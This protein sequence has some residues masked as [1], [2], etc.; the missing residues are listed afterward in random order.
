VILTDDQT[1]DGEA[2]YQVQAALDEANAVLSFLRAPYDMG[3]MRGGGVGGGGPIGGGGPWGGGGQGPWGTGGGPWGGGGTT[4]PGGRRGPMGS[5]RYPG[6]TTIGMD[7]S[8]SAGTAE[9]AKS[10]GG[11]VMSISDAS[12]FQDTLERLRQRYAL[13]FYWPEGSTDPERRTVVVSLA[14]STGARYARSEVRYRRAY[15]ATG[16]GRRTG[17]LIE[18]SREADPTDPPGVAPGRGTLSAGQSSER[19]SGNDAVPSQARAKR[20]VAVNESSG[21]LVNAVGVEPDDQSGRTSAT[22]NSKAAE[23]TQPNPA[24]EKRGGWPRVDEAKT[25]PNEGGPIGR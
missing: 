10:T 15:L 9:I 1:Q 24:P 4:W 8:H 2:G 13:H 16:V 17:G 21:P 23:G 11:D 14:R 20:R 7:P 12:A 25:H 22:Q 5:P 19:N 6:G 18:V 3:Y